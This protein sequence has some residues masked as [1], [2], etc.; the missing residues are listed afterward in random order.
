M[1]CC[2]YLFVCAFVLG[3][4]WRYAGDVSSVVM[5]WALFV[6]LNAPSAAYI[7]SIRKSDVLAKGQLLDLL[8]K[9]MLLMATYIY[10]FKFM[11][12][13]LVLSVYSSIYN[14]FVIWYSMRSASRA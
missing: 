1:P 6:F 9:A 5:I 14:I 8:G 12:A 11:S 2:P 4:S 3:E 10:Q 7:V 13:V